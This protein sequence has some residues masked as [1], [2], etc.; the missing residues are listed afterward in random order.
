MKSITFLMAVIT[1]LLV[2]QL[3]AQEVDFARQ[4]LPILSNKCFL[5]HGPDAEEDALRLDR[6]EDAT[7]DRGGYRAID[8]MNPNES[9]LL[10]RIHSSDDPMP[11]EDA[12]KQLTQ[13]ER[14]ILASWV[15]QGGS[16]K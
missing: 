8:Q 14:T 11:P 9:E 7:G 12:E 16:Y 1:T 13:K 6:A 10:R 5:C 4:V 15:K 2:S 3:R